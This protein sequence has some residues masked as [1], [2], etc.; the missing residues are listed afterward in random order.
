MAIIIVRGYLFALVRLDLNAG[1]L[2]IVAAAVCFSFYTVLL[3]KA[4]FDLA[5]LPL[6][7]LLLIGGMISALPFFI[8]EIMHDERAALNVKRT[9][10]LAYA[11]GP[12]G[13]LRYYLFNS[14]GG[15]LGASKARVF[16]SFQTPF[17]ANF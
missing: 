2:F 16:L 14:G 17:F 10:A 13:A 7:V 1:D 15:S 8:W 12:R 3:R 5:R 6:L 9:L 11:T 4:K